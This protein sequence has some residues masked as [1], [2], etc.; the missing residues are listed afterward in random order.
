MIGSGERTSADL[1]AMNDP[2][3]RK[4]AGMI[5]KMIVLFTEGGRWELEGFRALKE[6][7]R[8]E[9][10]QGVGIWARPPANAK[11]T[12]VVVS[13]GDSDNPVVIAIRDERTRQA[14]AAA[15]ADN[16][17]LLYNTLARVHVKADGTIH[18][19]AHNG[20]AERLPTW[21]DFNALLAWV[22]D[23][24]DPI[25]GHKHSALNVP[26]TA[27]GTTSAGYVGSPPAPT[28][29]TVLKAQ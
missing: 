25:T 19:R 18:V 7:V 3:A 6:R 8:A 10:F 15:I 1:A 28:G 24:F 23:Q 29:T 2:F 13:V 5:R 26:P 16:E 4:V 12:A 22:K 14:V 11:I 20:T 9:V 21:A 27:L 17:T